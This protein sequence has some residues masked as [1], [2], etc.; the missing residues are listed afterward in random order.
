VKLQSLLDEGIWA[1]KS[2]D[3]VS[4]RFKDEA[5]AEAWKNSYAKPARPPKEVKAPKP[6]REDILRSLFQNFEITVSDSFPDGDPISEMLPYLKKH[7][8]TV[9]DLNAA[10]RKFGRSKDVNDYLADLWDSYATDVVAGMERSG[11]FDE[12]SWAL[13]PNPWR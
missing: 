1:V 2:K 7:D 6:K 8:L 13:R 9:D 11:H 12:D 3:G 10:V 4:K 5:S